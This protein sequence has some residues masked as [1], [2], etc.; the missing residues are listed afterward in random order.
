MS[1]PPAFTRLALY[2]IVLAMLLAGCGERAVMGPSLELRLAPGWTYVGAAEAERDGDTV[3]L[4][5][6]G[7]EALDAAAANAMKGVKITLSVD[8]ILA[9]PK[10]LDAVRAHLRAATVPGGSRGA[11][12]SLFLRLP[13]GQT[14]AELAMPRARFSLTPIQVGE[15]TTLPGVVD[16]V[17]L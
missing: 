1:A 13:H 11:E 3:K 14:E 12:V 9:D 8:A 16:V 10:C 5:V 4:R 17:E 7:L 2:C 6:Q 15:L